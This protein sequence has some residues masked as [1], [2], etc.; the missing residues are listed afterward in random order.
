MEAKDILIK[1]KYT[2]SVNEH[3]LRQSIG[4]DHFYKK[5]RCLSEKD[6]QTFLVSSRSP[7]KEFLR[8]CGYE[9]TTHAGLYRSINPVIKM[10]RILSLNELSDE[11]HNAYL[12]CFASR[13]HQ[14]HSAF[15]ILKRCVF[16]FLDGQI[17]RV[18]MGLVYF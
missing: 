8:Q 13:R 1:F 2:E 6:V 15:D 10:V 16:S 12:K 4:Y 14:K 17:Q 7:G 5:A 11:L 18:L 9:A 3:A